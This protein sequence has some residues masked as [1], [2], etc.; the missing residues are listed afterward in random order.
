MKEPAWQACWLA[1][2]ILVLLLLKKTSSITDQLLDQVR[3]TLA[4]NMYR[5][6]NNAALIAEA[7]L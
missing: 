1:C 5:L 4:V 7:A 2:Q 6:K 3:H